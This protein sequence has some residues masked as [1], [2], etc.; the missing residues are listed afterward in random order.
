M[1]CRSVFCELGRGWLAIFLLMCPIQMFLCLQHRFWDLLW[2][3]NKWGVQTCWYVC[4]DGWFWQN[5]VGHLEK[6]LHGTE[7]AGVQPLVTDFLKVGRNQIFITVGPLPRP[8]NFTPFKIKPGCSDQIIMT[9][10]GLYAG[11]DGELGHDN[12]M[13]RED[14]WAIKFAQNIWNSL[15]YAHCWGVEDNVDVTVIGA[16]RNKVVVRFVA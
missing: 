15:W 13:V 7:R 1:L 12:V 10:S 11:W 3:R 4:G 2:P 8:C 16:L 9:A 14:E 5:S 6:N